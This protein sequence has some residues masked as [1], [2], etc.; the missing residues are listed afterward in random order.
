[1]ELRHNTQRAW[2]GTWTSA[3][4]EREQGFHLGFDAARADG[5]AG[6]GF[7][8]NQPIHGDQALVLLP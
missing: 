2:I 4:G 5:V 1:M 7:K 3:G 8:G 6:R